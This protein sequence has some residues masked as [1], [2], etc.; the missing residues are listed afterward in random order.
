MSTEPYEQHLLVVVVVG[1]RTMPVAED[2]LYGTQSSAELKEASAQSSQTLILYILRSEARESPGKKW[3]MWPPHD[4]RCQRA[5]ERE[6]GRGRG[7][8]GAV[9]SKD[10]PAPRKRIHPPSNNNSTFQFMILGRCLLQQSCRRL[11][12]VYDIANIQQAGE[13]ELDAWIGVSVIHWNL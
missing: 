5:R 6:S 12:E 13:I 7:G 9:E 10:S 4:D 11:V 3:P 1:D 2:C 8:R